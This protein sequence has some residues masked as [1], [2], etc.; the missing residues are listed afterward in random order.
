VADEFL[1]SRGLV[2]RR[3]EAYGLPG[4]LRLTVGTEAANRAVVAALKEFLA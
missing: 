2:L 1:V 4:A 3:M